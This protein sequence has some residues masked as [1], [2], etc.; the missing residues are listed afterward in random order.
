LDLFTTPLLPLLRSH[1]ITHGYAD[2]IMESVQLADR[3]LI[4]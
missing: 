2:I 4:E 1:R 3:I